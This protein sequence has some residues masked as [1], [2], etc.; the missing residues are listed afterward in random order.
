M[1]H[2]DR[3]KFNNSVE[4]L[5][6]CT[7]KENSQHLLHSG[8][9]W[10]AV[11]RGKSVSA[12]TRAKISAASK[13]RKGYVHTAETRAKFIKTMCQPIRCVTDGKTFAC[14]EEADHYY[15]YNGVA[16]KSAK[17]HRKTRDGRQFE[18]M[19]KEEYYALPL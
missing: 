10:G 16:T 13:G 3:N 1:N 19:S 4:N 6:W 18:Y 9:D 15:G 12:E 5:E 14:A 7:S 17:L 2:K 8:Y 11:S